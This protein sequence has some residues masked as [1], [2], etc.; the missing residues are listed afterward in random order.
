MKIFILI[1][2]LTSFS[3]IS[4]LAQDG[5]LQIAGRVVDDQQEPLS[6]VNI[7]LR[8]DASI[9][10]ITNAAGQFTLKL[11]TSYLGDSISF[12]SIGYETFTLPLTEARKKDTLV[13]VLQDKVYTLQEITITTDTALTLVKES[14][15]SLDRNLPK[16]RSVLQGFYREIIRSDY[17]YDRL[18][19]AAVDIFDRG[20]Q[21]AENE[22]RLQFKVREIRKSE[23]YRDMDW[24][25]SIFNYIRPVNGL[26]GQD[27]S[28]FSH[29]YIRVHSGFYTPLM[30]TPFNQSLFDQVLF[31]IDSVFAD[32]SDRILK[33]NMRPQPQVTHFLPYGTLYIRQ[34]D[35]A[36]QQVEVEV[37]VSAEADILFKVPGA[38][39]L[40]K[41]VIRYREYKGKM[42]LNFIYRKSFRMEL[43]YTKLRNKDR[44]EGAFFDEKF[45][46]TNEIIT[47][48]DKVG[49][50]RK[51]E[52][53]KKDRDLYS[54]DSV[55]DPVFW[56][57]YNCVN[58]RPL[59][60][61]VKKDLERETSLDEQFNKKK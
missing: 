45:F 40:H 36:I 39:Y 31:S 23:D 41:T 34:R 27:Q 21:P 60:P 10:T 18:V 53:Q 9:G 52:R 19:E 56:T 12:S 57:N 44:N 54:D 43:N 14:L 47:E 20:Y 61:S 4:L 24:M 16:Q 58:E 1:L 59:D 50:F 15:R 55:Y 17:T 11:P 35:F 26:H 42:Y 51:K 6:Y 48:K 37:K 3:S 32:G 13:V 22:S 29:D 25:M 46:V 2:L 30:F 33:I 5:S 8:N 38:D 7:S 28:L 49:R